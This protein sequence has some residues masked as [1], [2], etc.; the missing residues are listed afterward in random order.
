[1]TAQRSL[2]LALIGNGRIGAR[3]DAQATIV[4]PCFPRFD[5][6]PVFRALLDTAAAREARGL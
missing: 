1:M 5:G 6:D 2:D 3:V 4:W